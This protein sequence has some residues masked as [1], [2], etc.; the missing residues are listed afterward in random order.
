MQ[1]D[2]TYQGLS[3]K[4]STLYLN[5]L[6]QIITLCW[7]SELA[8]GF[9]VRSSAQSSVRRTVKIGGYYAV[10]KKDQGPGRWNVKFQKKKPTPMWIIAYVFDNSCQSCYKLEYDDA[11]KKR[12]C[13]S[14][15]GYLIPSTINQD[16]W[17]LVF[18]PRL[19]IGILKLNHA[20]L[21]F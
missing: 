18:Q 1:I 21:F 8:M 11:N 12:W 9:D 13:L 4:C 15:S 2:T 7:F 10:P 19:N 6:V 3:R 20:V 17:Q 5:L 14:K 16:N